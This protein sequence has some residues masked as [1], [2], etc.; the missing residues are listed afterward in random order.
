[1]FVAVSVYLYPAVKFFSLGQG[2][3]YSQPM[4]IDVSDC[5]QLSVYV[6]VCGSVFIFVCRL[7][8]SQK[9]YHIVSGFVQGTV[10]CSTSVSDINIKQC[11]TANVIPPKNISH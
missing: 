4:L 3:L 7:W 10:E 1:M 11:L 9:T 6:S 2:V 8:Q 5:L